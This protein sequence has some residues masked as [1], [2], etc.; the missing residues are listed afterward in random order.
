MSNFLQKLKEEEAQKSI[1]QTHTLTYFIVANG[2]V[3]FDM[4]EED[5]EG[6]SD[7]DEEEAKDSAP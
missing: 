1:F 2:E 4:Q 6:N 5:D 7:G 3:A